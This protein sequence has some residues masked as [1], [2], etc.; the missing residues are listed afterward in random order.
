MLPRWY[1]DWKL[2]DG[3]GIEKPVSSC[4]QC[5]TELYEG[6]DVL[7]F[8]NEHFCEKDCLLEFIGVRE[9]TL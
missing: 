2:H 4:T 1:D 8:D 6:E 3:I 7:E 5:G 9:V